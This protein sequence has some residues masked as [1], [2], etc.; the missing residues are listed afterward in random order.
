MILFHFSR[1]FV[2]LLVE[3]ERVSRLNF[4]RFRL[5]FK[6]LRKESQSFSIH[7]LIISAGQK[8]GAT[9]IFRNAQLAYRLYF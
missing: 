2:R 1:A 5:L 3:G 9:W 4:F 8:F 6:Q 7:H